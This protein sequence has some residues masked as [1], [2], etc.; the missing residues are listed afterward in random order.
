MSQ[1]Q[2]VDHAAIKTGQAL[3]IATL[4]VAFALSSWQVVAALAIIFLITS[5]VWGLGPFGLFYRFIL[6]PTGD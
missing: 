2:T 1:T 3:A 6:K 5:L 4:I